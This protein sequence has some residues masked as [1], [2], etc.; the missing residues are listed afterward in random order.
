MMAVPLPPRS[1]RSRRRQHHRPVDGRVVERVEPERAAHFVE[2]QRAEFDAAFERSF[3]R[4]RIG[5]LV[6]PMQLKV[7]R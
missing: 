7:R 6:E 2:R 1:A 4:A 5:V 3:G